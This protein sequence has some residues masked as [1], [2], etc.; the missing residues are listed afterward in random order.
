MTETTFTDALSSW[1]GFRLNRMQILK[2]YKNCNNAEKR[3]LCPFAIM[4]CVVFR[5]LI[6]HNKELLS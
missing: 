6:M 5:S 4:S 2:K 1:G 3:N